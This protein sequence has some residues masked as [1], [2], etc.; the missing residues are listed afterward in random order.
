MIVFNVISWI[1]NTQFIITLILSK[2]NTLTTNKKIEIEN[3]IYLFFMLILNISKSQIEK[4]L[5]RN[6]NKIIKDY[7]IELWTKEQINFSLMAIQNSEY[8]F[9]LNKNLQQFQNIWHC[10]NS[11]ILPFLITIVLLLIVINSWKINTAIIV[12]FII[13]NIQFFLSQKSIQT[14]WKITKYIKKLNIQYNKNYNKTNWKPFIFNSSIRIIINI[15]LYIIIIYNFINNPNINIELLLLLITNIVLYNSNNIYLCFSKYYYEKKRYEMYNK[16]PKIS[17]NSKICLQNFSCIINNKQIFNNISFNDKDDKIII[18]GH[19]KTQ[20]LSGI[21]NLNDEIFSGKCNY[22]NIKNV[23]YIRNQF[24]QKKITLREYL[25]I[26][27][28]EYNDEQLTNILSDIELLESQFL[29]NLLD[30]SYSQQ[31][32]SDEI[33]FLIDIY[34]SLYITNKIIIIDNPMYLKQPWINIWSKNNN[35]IIIMTNEKLNNI[36]EIQFSQINLQN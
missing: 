2:L 25:L 34:K 6:F 28:P 7:Q 19:G 31:N 5:F 20:L 35:K 32:F 33:R 10:I 14:D 1:S 23:V 29:F 27:F 18:T 36:D 22:Q 15:L 11:D 13:L 4:Q 8:K 24:S 12:F 16:T 3:Y 21:F 26:D 9:L 30:R 17:K